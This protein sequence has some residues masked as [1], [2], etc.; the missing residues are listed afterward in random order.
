[1]KSFKL[2]V[3]ATPGMMAFEMEVAQPK[4][5]ERNGPPTLMVDQEGN[6]YVK[7]GQLLSGR[8]D[9]FA[10]RFFA[11]DELVMLNNPFIGKLRC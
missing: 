4:D 2:K 6:F 10:Y 9:D 3:E 7:I 8:P 5:Y 11:K 1:V